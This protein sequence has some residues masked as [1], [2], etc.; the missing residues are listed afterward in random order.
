[1]TSCPGTSTCNLGI[2]HSRNAADVAAEVV[3]A[4]QDT[5]LTIKISGCHNSCGQ[6]HVGTIGFYGAVKRINGRPAPHYRLMV[7]GGIDEQGATF[8]TGYPLLPAARVQECVERLVA[9]A[10]ANKTA[11][12]TT[13]DWLRRA[14][15]DEVL[16]VLADLFEMDETTATEGDFVDIGLDQPFEIIKRAGECAA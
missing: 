9:T 5:D 13:G 16:P 15:K 2:T 11:D 14:S 7:G 10:D 6:H 3:A 8:G 12:E 1:M 4:R